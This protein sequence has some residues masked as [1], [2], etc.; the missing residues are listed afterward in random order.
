MEEVE[1]KIIETPNNYKGKIELI[2]TILEDVKKRKII[3]YRYFGKYKK[4]NTII[5][6]FVNTFNAISVCSLVLTF[7]PISTI[8]SIIA[9]TSTSISTILSAIHSSIDIENKVQSHNISYCQYNDIYRDV[10]ARLLRNGLSSSDLDNLLNEINT[11]MSL[12]EDQSL[13]ITIK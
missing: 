13:P 6:S 5:K 8:S 7:I 10:S 12:I 11:R 1:L 2:R 4:I 9:L 3:H